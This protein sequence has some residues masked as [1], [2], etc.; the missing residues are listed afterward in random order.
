MALSASGVFE[1]QSGATASNVNGGYFNPANANMLTD[2][3][4]DTNTA[5]TNA[6]I[7]SSASYNFVNADIGNWLYVKSGT[8]WQAGWYKITAVSSNKATLSAA[9]GSANVVI[10]VNNLYV[11]ST[12]LGCTSDNT[13]TL[14]SGTFTIDYSQSAA[15]I[16][17]TSVSDYVSVGSSTTLT[18]ATA[19]FTPVMVGNG[20]H[21]N[22]AGTGGFGVVGWY[23]ISSY[24]NATTVVTD[25]TT[26]N[27]TA[28]ANGQGKIGGA[29][30]LGSSDDAVWE[31]GL[32][33]ASASAR[34][35][36]QGGSSITYTLGGIVSNSQGGNSVWPIIFEGYASVRGDRPTGSTRPTL[37]AGANTVVWGTNN[38][39]IVSLAG[40]GTNGT[41]VWNSG[42]TG[43][44]QY[45]QCK[46]FNTAS[47]SNSY[48]FRLAGADTS[49]IACEASSL[50]GY[51]FSFSEDK[52]SIFGCYVHDCVIGCNIAATIFHSIVDCIFENI[53]TTAIDFNAGNTLSGSIIGNT[54]YG[55]ENKLGTGINMAAGTKNIIVLNNIF[56]G[57]ATGITHA[58]TQT[59]CYGNWNDFFNNTNDVSAATQWQKGT[60]DIAVNPSFTNVTQ[61][62]GTTG[63][64]VGGNGQL[65]DTSKNFTSLG[66]AAGQ[67]VYVVSGTGST[68]SNYLI[69]S[70]ST[71]TNPNDTLNITLPAGPGTNTTADKV[72]QITLGHNFLPTGAI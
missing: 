2:L 3:A 60:N 28:L 63:K 33:S 64:F 42:G 69:D 4:T 17:S 29:L 70:I 12:V 35:F 65:I 58:S 23:E 44:G 57:L 53:K 16:T 56:Y 5:N 30:S 71:T 61:V 40:T 11:P 54:I 37:A 43:S 24:T 25:R 27:G 9:I 26:N 10:V 45:M 49:A 21:L 46:V 32:S 14:S 6:P 7:V 18:S 55:A 13:A 62:T 15:C 47:A 34:F 52:A 36:F 41:G 1:I 67:I 8:H 22:N 59:D 48:A 72:Y 50:R 31:L 68:V 38:I 51:G 66:V 20:F 39:R 19:A